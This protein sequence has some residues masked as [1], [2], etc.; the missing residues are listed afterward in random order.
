[1]YKT[2]RTI[3]IGT[4]VAEC[5]WEPFSCE[6][7]ERTWHCFADKSVFTE[8]MPMSRHGPQ[9]KASHGLKTLGVE[10]VVGNWW[11]WWLIGARRGNI[12]GHPGAIPPSSEAGGGYNSRKNLKM[13]NKS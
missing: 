10:A 5:H 13:A 4:L 2:S 8:H 11:D 3:Q 12:F 6:L 9:A 7:F 1:M